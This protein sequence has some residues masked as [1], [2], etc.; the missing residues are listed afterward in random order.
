MKNLFKM[1]AICIFLSSCA[2]YISPQT[3]LQ[4][5]QGKK[6]LVGENLQ[7]A[8]NHFVEAL[9]SEPFQSELHLNLGLIQEFLKE[10]PK[11]LSFYESAERYAKTPSRHFFSLYNQGEV[12]GKDKK[13][14]E[15]LN[16]YQK[17][18]AYNPSSKEIKTNIELL[19]NM[20]SQGGGQGQ[21]QD[22]KQD[23]NQSKNQQNQQNQQ[24]SDS[25]QK[26]K[27]D[28]SQQDQQKEKDQ[29]KDYEKNK[30]YKPRP[31]K[32]E[33]L[34]EGDVKKILGELKQQEQKIRANFNRKQSKE[35]P[36][37]K[38]W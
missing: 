32:G 28:P 37:D 2:D 36:R 13:V 22:Q 24:K 15:A 23:Q 33:E 1:G 16:A 19:I 21:K 25:D 7:E 5:E 4:T 26:D 10:H 38:D 6:A 11:A 9:S 34:S 3:Y 29:P 27:K 18:L 30:P 8:Q 35:Q 17:A 20:Q 31:F 12:L 14:D